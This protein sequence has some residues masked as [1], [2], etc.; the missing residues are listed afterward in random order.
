VPR[1]R[2]VLRRYR[3]ERRRA[4]H[5]ERNRATPSERRATSADVFV[6]VQDM[7]AAPDRRRMSVE[8]VLPALEMGGVERG[9]LEVARRLVAEGHR[10]T[11]ISAGGRLVEQLEHEGSTHLAWDVGANR[12][13]TLRWIPRLRR[14]LRDARPDVLHL[15]SRLFVCLVFCVWLG[16]FVAVCF[17]LVFFVFGFFLSGRYS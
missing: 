5:E 8:Q 16:L 10:S 12:L 6:T 13:S 17:V 9:T 3:H 15:R 2:P 7:S 11:V 4:R 1:T 14:F